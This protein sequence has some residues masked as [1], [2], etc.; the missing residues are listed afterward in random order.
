MKLV[1]VVDDDPRFCA[2]VA[3]GLRAI[4]VATITAST[5]A[6][7][8]IEVAARR[9]D[10]IVLDGKLPDLDGFSWLSR[11][12]EIDGHG[13]A[14]PVVFA[15]ACWRDT[16]SYM[17]LY[18]ELKVSAIVQK[19][20]QIPYLVQAIS[21]ALG[22]TPPTDIKVDAPLE[23]VN[24]LEDDL[25]QII[26]EYKAE[27]P[28]LLADLRDCIHRIQFG[29]NLTENYADAIRAA[30]TIRGTAGSMG[31]K[32]LANLLRIVEER[33]KAMRNAR[34]ES[35]TPP[36]SAFRALV[37]CIAAAAMELEPEP[38]AQERGDR[39]PPRA[40]APLNVLVLDDD[41]FFLKR[42]EHLLVEH[43]MNV[44]AFSDTKKIYSC[45]DQI[46]PDVVLLD[47]N[48][49]GRNGFEI[50]RELRSMT[51][52][53]DTPIVVVT[54]E[55]FPFIES[56]SIDLGATRFVSKPIN[57]MELVNIIR[58]LTSPPSKPAVNG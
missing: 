5:A 32:N 33:L 4:D 42:I 8:A 9:P 30:H 12:R 45:M 2:M 56:A 14:V 27:L 1:L 22:V 44:T 47:L 39:V 51:R 36:K 13:Q 58:E 31:M 46:K 25:R 6:D 10:L 55:S 7:A 48:I 49:P 35:K 18:E 29:Y 11:L 54:A 21:D 23:I 20:V 34:N 43:G 26:N 24:S 50:C 38:T 28:G 52:W 53:R 41:E 15:S 16:E 40:V 19:P 57:N 17:R 37:N 3:A